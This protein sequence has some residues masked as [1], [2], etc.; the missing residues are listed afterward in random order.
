MYVYASVCMCIPTMYVP[1]HVYTTLYVSMYVYT[2]LYVCIW[3]IINI[4]VLIGTT[5]HPYIQILTN[6]IRISIFFY[7]SSVCWEQRK[8]RA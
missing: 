4:K 1:I 2:T 7:V 8:L 5:F 3:L 6:H